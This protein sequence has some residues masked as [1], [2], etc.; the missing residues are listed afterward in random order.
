MIRHMLAVVVV[1]SALVGGDCLVA[2]AQNVDLVTLPRRDTVQLT[3]YNS[4]DITLAKEVRAVTL[5][6][7]ANRLQF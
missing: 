3:I 2:S 5:K 6:K 4:E 7:G 1:G